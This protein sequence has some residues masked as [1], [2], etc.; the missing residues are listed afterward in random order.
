MVTN[1]TEVS[2]LFHQILFVHLLSL[3]SAIE[4]HSVRLVWL[5]ILFCLFGHKIFTC[6]RNIVQS[7]KKQS[8]KKVCRILYFDCLLIIFFLFLLLFLLSTH[9]RAIVNKLQATNPNTINAFFVNKRWKQRTYQNYLN[10]CM[11]AVTFA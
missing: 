2:Y 9:Y 10:A 8:E 3:F 11:Y 6:L 1:S 4:I 7:V 5:H